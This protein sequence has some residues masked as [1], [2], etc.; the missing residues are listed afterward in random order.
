MFWTY[1]VYIFRELVFDPED[2]NTDLTIAEMEK[3]HYSPL[4]N[5]A[6]EMLDGRENGI[7]LS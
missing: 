5:P 1:C 4:K 7:I 2:L 6:E 3:V